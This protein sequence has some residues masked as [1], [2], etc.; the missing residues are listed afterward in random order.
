MERS[1]LKAESIKLAIIIP[2]FNEQ[3]TIQKV[4]NSVKFAGTVIVVDDCSTDETSNMAIE[5]GAVVVKHIINKGYDLALESGFAK[6]NELKM[7]FAI[8]LDADGQHPSEVLNTMIKNFEHGQLLVLG[9][10]DKL[11]RLSEKLFSFYSRKKFGVKD[12]CCGLKGYSMLFYRQ[13]K[14]FTRYPS[15]GTDLMF[16]ALH[17]GAKAE[18]ISFKV[19]ERFDKPRFGSVLTSNL[20]ILNALIKTIKYY[21]F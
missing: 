5:A 3:M 2:A 8:T 20:K 1:H 7:D 21:G 18:Q 9:V 11:P 19:K 16:S 13:H 12:P 14:C 17:S 6:A 15:I 4:V 10:R